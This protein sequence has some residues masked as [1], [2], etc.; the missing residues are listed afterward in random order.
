MQKKVLSFS[1]RASGWLLSNSGKVFPALTAKVFFRLYTTPPGRKPSGSQLKM[2]N[3]AVTGSIV[4]S[5][6]AFD[7]RPLE[8]ATY[9][10]GGP[11]KK[12]LLLHGWASSALGFEA[13]TDALVRAGYEVISYDGPAHGSSG[14]RRTTLIQWMHILDQY[15]RQEGPVY[16]IVGHSIGALN[17]AL[18]L[19]RKEHPTPKLVLA[20]PPLSAPAF[21][22]DSFELF[23]IPPKVRSEVFGLVRTKYRDDLIGMDL[24]HYIGRIGAG[25]ILLVYDE[26]DEMVKHEELRVY[27]ESYP[28]MQTFPVKGEG[29]FRILKNRAVIE[30]ILSFLG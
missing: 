26:R 15:L 16:A 17:A 9:R 5:Q 22:Q 10:W 1:L 21:F 8:I 29:H 30:R 7:A 20:S 6:Y 19:A 3:R 11:G 12:V 27:S 23:K 14:G 2:K 28:G 18:T 13:L 4:S 25:Q 24:Q